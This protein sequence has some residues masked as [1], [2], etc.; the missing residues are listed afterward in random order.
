[1]RSKNLRPSAIWS[2]SAFTFSTVIP[3]QTA[4]FSEE[5]EHWDEV[6]D[7]AHALVDKQTNS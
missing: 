3:L 1:M 4:L 2:S 6:N 7:L 5:G